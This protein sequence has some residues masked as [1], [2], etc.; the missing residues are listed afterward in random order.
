MRLVFAV[1][2]AAGVVLVGPATAG[3]SDPIVG[4]WRFDGGV[5]R[6][7]QSG[8]SFAGVV[9]SSTTLAVCPHRAG[10]RMWKLEPRG[11]NFYRGTHLSFDDGAPGCGDRVSLSASWSLLSGDRLV[12]RVAERTGHS[13]ARCGSFETLCFTLHRIVGA[14]E[15]TVGVNVDLKGLDGETLRGSGAR[16]LV[17]ERDG[18]RTVLSVGRVRSVASTNVFTLSVVRSTGESCASGSPGTLRVTG[19]AATIGVCGRS[20]ELRGMVALSR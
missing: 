9:V 10:E 1:A 2:V 18:E 6:V 20:T 4:S 13:P 3:P 16:G 5:V 19:F 12:L 14:G 15:A 7:T 11:G 8:G 17:L